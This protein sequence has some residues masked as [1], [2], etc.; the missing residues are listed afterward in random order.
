VCG[1]I[2]RLKIPEFTELINKYDVFVCSECKLDN[3]DVINVN[4]YSFL[5]QPRKQQ[6]LRKSGGVGFFIKNSINN[7]IEIIPTDSDYIF[8]VKI[9][10]TNASNDLVIGATYIPPESSRFFK[11]EEFD[12]FE[13]EI[14]HMS[15]QYNNLLIAGDLNAHTGSLSDFSQVDNF[16]FTQ[17]NL[18]YDAISYFNQSQ[19]LLDNGLSLERNTP[20]NKINSTGKNLINICKNNNLTI[21][22]GRYSTDRTTGKSTY[23]DA[24]VIDYMIS[25]RS[26]LK[27]LN[28]FEIN[29]LD[30]LYSDGHNLL[31]LD[32]LLTPMPIQATFYNK[33]KTTKVKLNWND[34]KRTEFANNI[35][36][37]SIAELQNLLCNA[38]S[39]DVCN[40][41]NINLILEKI[42][43]IFQK[44]TNI[45]FNETR[46]NQNT[47]TRTYKKT[48][49]EKPWFGKQCR[50]KRTMYEGCS[51][52]SENFV[53]SP[54]CFVS[55]T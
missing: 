50:L 13:N 37:M 8:W 33:P 39:S 44:S 40:N 20:D 23:R 16:L 12:L 25:S 29:E 7:L 35:D 5:S 52:S 2:N 14:I 55:N 28:Y 10:S 1:L 51:G 17:M 49:D 36:P 3:L 11:Q 21:L 6:Y 46:R 48:F 15:S 54:I 47:N 4:G 30:C 41:A 27:M 42:S 45:T 43:D 53:I 26:M 9:H 18:D 34:N 24:S 38:D 31:S 19:H 22:N 32:L